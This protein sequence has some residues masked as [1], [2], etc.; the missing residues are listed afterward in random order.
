MSSP[1]EMAERQGRMLAELAELGLALA[2]ELQARALSAEAP[3]ETAH[4]AEAFHRISRSVRQSLALEAKLTRESVRDARD[5]REHQVRATAARRAARKAL[6]C[7]A[8]ERAIW[9]EVEAP[10]TAA[11][12]YRD[13]AHFVEREAESETFLDEPVEAQVAR[14]REA[15]GVPGRGGDDWD[16][17]DDEADTDGSGDAEDAAAEGATAG[18][19][20]G[21]PKPP[22]NASGSPDDH[23]YDSA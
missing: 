4:L 18:A 21:P 15:L 10:E 14:I 7:E 2:R 12:I 5:Q 8:V 23:W 16:L 3:Q 17:D 19:S 1:A 11:P 22:P 9:D 6:L 20:S 13:V